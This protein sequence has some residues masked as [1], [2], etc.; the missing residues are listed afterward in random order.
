MASKNPNNDITAKIILD[1]GYDPCQRYPENDIFWENIIGCDPGFISDSRKIYCYKVLE[2]KET[3]TDGENYCKNDFDAELILFDTNSE[4]QD[5]I[6]L[7]K[8]GISTF[9]K[10]RFVINVN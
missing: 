10:Y 2:T 9:M 6:M 8:S 1:G 5:I 4:V 7:I 3:L